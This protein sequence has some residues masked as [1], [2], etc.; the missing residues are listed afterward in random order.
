[1]TRRTRQAAAQIRRATEQDL[2]QMVELM[3]GL[4]DFHALRD[5]IFTT[6]PDA[7]QAW[8]AFVRKNMASDQAAVFVAERDDRVVG[9]CMAL[10]SKYPPVL[11]VSTYGELMDLMVHADYRRQGI[12]ESLVSE[13]RAWYGQRGIHRIEVRVAV[14]NEI[15][16]AFWRKMGFQPYLETLAVEIP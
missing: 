12:G 5:P 15:S 10:I 2:A 14:T 6:R 11:A 3:K 8:L 16:T 4:M 1:M 13:V 9:Y 7:D